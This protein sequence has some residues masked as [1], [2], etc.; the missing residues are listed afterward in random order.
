ME[1]LKEKNKKFNLEKIM[2]ENFWIVCLIIAFIILL[3][4]LLSLF[5]FDNCNS[6][7]WLNRKVFS[8]TKKYLETISLEFTITSIWAIIAF[9]YWFKKYER[10]KDFEVISNFSL[11]NFS[12]NNIDDI[13]KWVLA[14]NLNEKNYLSK[15]LWKI[16]NFNNSIMFKEIINKNEFI[17]NKDLFFKKTILILNENKDFSDK[18]INTILNEMINN[19]WKEIKNRENDKKDDF[20]DIQEYYKLKKYNIE[21]IK[22]LINK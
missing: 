11:W 1:N 15:E 20:F 19:Y 21:N 18:I 7:I 3:I 12:I 4:Y 9:W 8:C 16:I 5:P 14:F 22:K 13:H 17:N 6:E 2:N 10:D